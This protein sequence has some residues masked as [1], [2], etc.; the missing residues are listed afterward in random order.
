MLQSL[1]RARAL[2]RVIRGTVQQAMDEQ[3]DWANPAARR[4]S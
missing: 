3:L 4:A 1:P 2:P